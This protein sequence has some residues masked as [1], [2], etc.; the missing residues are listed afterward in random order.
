MKSKLGPLT[1]IAFL[2]VLIVS[3]ILTGEPPT[4]EDGVADVVKHYEDNYDSI[5]I[6]SMLSGLA[7]ALLV[8]FAGYLRKVLSAAEGAEG[9]LS[10]VA[11]TGAVI[12]AIGATFDTTIQ[13]AIA[14]AVDGGIDDSAVL[15]MQALWDNDFLVFAMGTLVFLS[16]FA[17]SVLKYGALPKW[18]GY[19][20]AVGAIC[21]FTP[22]F[23]VGVIASALVVLTSSVV[24]T[25]RAGTTNQPPT[26]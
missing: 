11:F 23:W 1:G 10:T 14:E 20:A 15:T 25:M 7:A 9:W 6:G 17:I 22:V 5:I 3:A 26:T 4:A 21:I 2:A 8:F 13:F 19:V 16:S 18:I 24:L 12:I